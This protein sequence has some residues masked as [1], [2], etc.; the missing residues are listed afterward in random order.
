MFCWFNQPFPLGIQRTKRQDRR[1]QNQPA[2][3]ERDECS[4]MTQKMCVSWPWTRWY[5]T[6]ICMYLYIYIHYYYYYFYYYYFYYYYYFALYCIVLYYTILY[7]CIL[8]YI[9][10]NDI[11]YNIII[12]IYICNIVYI[13]IHLSVRLFVDVDCWLT[14]T[15]AF[16]L[17]T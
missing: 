2:T 1:D 10:L 17:G 13:Y 9:T 16:N 5:M 8:Y 14:E 15:L 3:G 11:I 6:Q 4:G 12:H 7:H